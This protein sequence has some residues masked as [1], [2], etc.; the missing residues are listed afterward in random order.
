[1]TISQPQNSGQLV[2][3]DHRRYLILIGV[4]FR[5]LARRPMEAPG[6]IFIGLLPAFCSIL[7]DKI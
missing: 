5:S 2:R 7:I 6:E 3:E 4:D 1:M